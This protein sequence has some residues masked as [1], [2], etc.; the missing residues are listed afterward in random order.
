MTDIAEFAGEHDRR[1]STR[2]SRTCEI[3][4]AN[5]GPVP[6]LRP[7]HHREPQGLLVLVARGPRLRLRDL[8]VAR[9]ASSSRRRSPRELIAT[10]R[11]ER[12]SPASGRAAASSFRA[13]LAL[14]QNEEGKLARR[15]RRG[16]G[17]G[18]REGA[19]RRGRNRGRR[20]DRRG[21]SRQGRQSRWRR[22]RRRGRLSLRLRRVSFSRSAATIN[23]MPLRLITGPANA[24]K[25]AVVLNAL[26]ESS[27][28]R[29]VADSRRS[30]RG[31]RRRLPAPAG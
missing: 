14:Q 31:R 2:R 9:S 5:L 6:G 25:A 29:A 10:G 15:V 22:L 23:S 24:E 18:G 3:P 21:R 27:V 13:Q 11:T 28:A 7:G 20:R 30:N 16:V 1:C 26:R 17:E 12:R 19:G 8:E 4:R